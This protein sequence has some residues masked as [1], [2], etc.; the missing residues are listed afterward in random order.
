[1]AWPKR[2]RSQGQED[3][4]AAAAEA[5]G[6]AAAPAAATTT[7][8]A[9]P[10][11]SLPLSTPPSPPPAA[12]ATNPPSPQSNL[13]A[14]LKPR[15]LQFLAAC[16]RQWFLIA[17]L[18]GVA[19]AAAV[20]QLGAK[21]GWLK[22]EYSVRIPAIVLIFLISGSGLKTS[23]LARA[24]G[25]L[26]AHALVQGVSLGVTPLVGWGVGAA[27][28]A[29]GGLPRPLADGIVVMSCMPTT[30]S[31]NVVYTDLVRLLLLFLLGWGWGGGGVGRNHAF[32]AP[33]ARATAAV[34]PR[35]TKTQ[36]KTTPPKPNNTKQAGGNESIALVN[37]VLGN[38]VGI[39]VSPAWITALVPAP[40]AATA[41]TTTTAG[42][43]ASP[44]A[45]AA[46]L[47]AA[48]PYA[49][50]L[51]ELGYLVLAPL[52]AGQLLQ[53]FCP[54]AVSTVRS[55]VNLSDVS[56]LCIV[57]IVWISFCNTFFAARVG[58]GTPTTAADAAAAFFLC[59]ALLA[60]FALIAIAA[61]RL[62][63]P[64]C[65]GGGRSS[66]AD[67]LDGNVQEEVESGEKAAAAAAAA[68]PPSSVVVAAAAP[69]S[70]SSVGGAAAAE[71]G[72]AT[73]PATT[74]TPVPTQHQE[75]SGSGSGSLCFASCSRLPRADAV[76]VIICG[77]TKTLAL[78]APLISVMYG[79]SDDVGLVALPLVVYHALQ[80]VVG[81]PLLGPL[82]RWRHGELELAPGGAWCG[83]RRRGRGGGGGEGAD[84]A[85]AP[86]PLPPQA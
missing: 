25:N 61:S 62:P 84:D 32:F 18:C 48:V 15:L 9:P 82:R 23:V 78:G 14:R 80:C 86:P 58:K 72:R 57:L 26:R 77:A 27:L 35:K 24:A 11:P 65:E 44:P 39:F 66:K 30:I 83:R 75:S 6:E 74:S 50:V 52:V 10:P 38:L 67:V 8:A 20:P 5:A 85:A 68:A 34:S 70:A 73:T 43:A 40:P 2:G 59:A 37:A 54:R 45:D 56:S 47:Q 29:S 63:T 60:A 1:M 46:S 69:S 42:G 33:R 17:L 22:A 3:A 64:S 31:T 51:G 81:A 53:Y 12:A 21:N 28:R 55:K 71:E 49:S 36:N 79:K 41:T 76:A 13:A 16:R 19:F 7:T 4:A